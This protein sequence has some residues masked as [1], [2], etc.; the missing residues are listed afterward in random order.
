[1]GDHGDRPQS[2]ARGPGKAP[3]ALLDPARH[4]TVP[5]SQLVRQAETAERAGF[6]AINVSDHFQPWWEP[7]ESGQAWTL[8]KATQRPE[9]FR[10]DWHDPE[11]MYA[12]AEETISD[13]EFRESYIVG[14]DPEVHAERI[15]EVERMG[16]TVVCLQNGSG[17]APLNALE[18]HGEMVLPALRDARVT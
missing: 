11:A 13:E 18:V 17:A 5:P 1:M 6:D 7:G 10:E 16:A 3:H 4:R 14:S 12:R 15:R 9:Y 2:R 8:L